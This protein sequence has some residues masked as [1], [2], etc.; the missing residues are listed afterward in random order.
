MSVRGQAVSPA[1]HLRTAG[2]YACGTGRRWLSQ[3]ISSVT[4][5]DRVTCR[6]CIR[7]R[8]YRDQEKP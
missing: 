3:Q 5:R 1:V 7:T 4:G 6:A 2:G 8:A